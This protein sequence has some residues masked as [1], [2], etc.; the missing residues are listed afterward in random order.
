MVE[1]ET[2]AAEVKRSSLTEEWDLY[3]VILF[4]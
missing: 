2:P 4:I 3:R 1:G